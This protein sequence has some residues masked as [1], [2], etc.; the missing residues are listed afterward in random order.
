MGTAALLLSEECPTI[1]ASN[2]FPHLLSHNR[3]Y[4]SHADYM[5][6]FQS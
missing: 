1:N 4:D 6:V 5:K 3:V 2:V